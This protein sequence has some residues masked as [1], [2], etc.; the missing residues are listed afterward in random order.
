M[1]EV[2]LRSHSSCPLAMLASLLLVDASKLRNSCRQK[3]KRCLKGKISEEGSCQLHFNKL[4]RI[5]VNVCFPLMLMHQSQLSK[6]VT[7]KAC[8]C[9]PPIAD[10][11]MRTC[12]TCNSPQQYHPP[13]LLL[14]CTNPP[15]PGVD[16]AGDVVGGVGDGIGVVGEEAEP[17]D[18][19]EDEGD[20]SAMI[21]MA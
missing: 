19:G 11:R 13:M 9:S 17:I 15:L 1:E 4:E 12:A 14:P 8:C 3:I 7:K 18:E 5:N 2:V 21:G 16:S 10:L 20:P 6:H